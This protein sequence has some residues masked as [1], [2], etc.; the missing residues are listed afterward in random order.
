[1]DINETIQN[2][3]SEKRISPLKA[4]KERCIDCSGGSFN[5]VKVCTATNCALYPFRLGKNP[6][7][8]KGKR[9]LTDDQRKEL[10][11]RMAKARKKKSNE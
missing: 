8:K 3:S 5:E 2:T 11:E 10:A 7:S 9:V 4:I 1:M 6:F